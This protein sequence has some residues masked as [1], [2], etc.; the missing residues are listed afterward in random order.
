[1]LARSLHWEGK[2]QNVSAGENHGFDEGAEGFPLAHLNA[3]RLLVVALV[4]AGYA[5]TMARGPGAPEWAHHLGYDPSWFGLQVLFFLSGAMA[6]RSVEAGRRGWRYLGSRVRRTLPVLALYTLAVVSVLYP[7]L[8][9]AGALDAAGLWRLAA[10]FGETVTLISPGGPMPGALDDAA[11]ACLLQGT[12]WTLRWGAALHLCTLFAARLRPN[13][14]SVGRLAI[15]ALALNVLG[16]G[17]Y[18]WLGARWLEPIAPGLR[19]A[20]PW[21]LGIAAFSFR[22]RLPRTPGSYAIATLILLGLGGAHQQLLGWSPAVEILGTVAWCAAALGL[23]RLRPS[24]VSHVPPLALPVYLGV[25]PTAQTILYLQ[26]DIPTGA[27]IGATLLV[28]VALAYASSVVLSGVFKPPAAS[29]LKR[30]RTA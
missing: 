29:Q 9:Q 28:S 23:M 27:L 22:H 16:V 20:Y 2:R 7:A 11:Y 17:A 8:C 3:V 13:G 25:W 12:V 4:G 5:S 18:V 21:V 30:P 1:M 19:L 24:L 26:P 15:A 10:Y 6:W 14:V